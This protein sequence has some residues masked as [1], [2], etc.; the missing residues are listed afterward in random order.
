MKLQ[1]QCSWPSHVP[2][3]PK[4]HLYSYINIFFVHFQI[5]KTI[6]V[7]VV[8]C[9]IYKSSYN[10]SQLNSPPPPFSFIPLL[11]FLEYFQQVSFFH[12][13]PWGYNIST[14]LNFLYPFFISSPLPLIP[15]PRQ[16]LFYLP[17]LCFWKKGHFCFFKITIQGVSYIYIYMCVCVCV[18]VCVYK[19][20]WIVSSP[21][22]FSLPQSPSYCDFN[23][24]KNSIFTLM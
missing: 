13:H 4:P 3:Y 21:L 15:T 12:F 24:F 14:I 19:I 5:F 7:L 2:L 22:F 6:V 16:N 11:P 17:F 20:T 9:D 1:Q 23:R 18:C 8:H 10:I